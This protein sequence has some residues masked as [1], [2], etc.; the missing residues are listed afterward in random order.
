MHS[1]PEIVAKLARLL[2]GKKGVEEKKM[3][4]GVCFMFNG[5]ICVGVYYDWLIARV[6]EDAAE[7]GL[8][9]SYVEP[10]DI[11]GR[12]MKGWLKVS[13]EGDEGDKRLQHWV[14]A[15]LAFVNTLPKK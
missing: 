12:P 8:N 4:G 10:M 9:E 5:N 7:K 14:D 11:T 1:N 2:D 6:G 3:F 13:L 15:S